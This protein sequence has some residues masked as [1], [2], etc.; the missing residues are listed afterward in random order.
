[1]LNQVKRQKQNIFLSSL[2]ENRN[3]SSDLII[4]EHLK[5]LGI[6]NMFKKNVLPDHTSWTQPS[7][8]LRETT[9]KC[10]YSQDKH[11]ASPTVVF[12]LYVP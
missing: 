1:M 4:D 6:N 11:T 9:A 10:K 2:I 8:Q 7:L 5:H 12:C 3:V